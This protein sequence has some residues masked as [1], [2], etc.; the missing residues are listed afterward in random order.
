M[1]ENINHLSETEKEVFNKFGENQYCTNKELGALLFRSEETVKSH[2]KHIYKK[3]GYKGQKARHKLA[4][5]WD[6]IQNF[7]RLSDL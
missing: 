2:M 7:T 6:E 4:D 3:L 5:L 1:Y